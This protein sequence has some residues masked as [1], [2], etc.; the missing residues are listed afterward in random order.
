MV[1]GIDVTSG[2]AGFIIVTFII[3][4]LLGIVVKRVFK[5]ALA[6]VAL[7]VVLVLTG[8][9][10]LSLGQNQ[11]TKETIYHTFSSTLPSV[12]NTAQQVATILPLTSAAF[13]AGI[14]LGLWKG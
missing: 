10:N 1:F 2:G 7:V 4:L 5:L 8:Y 13:L 3:G 11:V 9:V 12:V 6:I 14:G